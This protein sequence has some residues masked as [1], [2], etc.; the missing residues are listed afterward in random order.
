V[1]LSGTPPYVPH[2]TIDIAQP[3]IRLDVAPSRAPMDAEITVRVLDASPGRPVTVTARSTD[4]AGQAWQT[5]ATFLAD[6]RGTVDLRRDPPLP[7]SSYAGTDPMGLVWSLRPA[8]APNQQAARD[9]LA[10]QPLAV[11]AQVDGSSPAT[12]EVARLFVPDGLARTQVRERGLVGVLYRPAGN[13][14]LPAVLMLGG[15]EGGLGPAVGRPDGTWGPRG[16]P[17]RQP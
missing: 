3:T 12:A 7:G 17:P 14:P 11:A 1:A 5:A 10:P 8:G 2:M 13:Q 16:S 9:R 4:A 6:E 15:A